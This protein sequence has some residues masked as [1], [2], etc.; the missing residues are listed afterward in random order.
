MKNEFQ[1]ALSNDD[2]HDSSAAKSEL[3]E[4]IDES[5]EGKRADD[6]SFL[7]IFQNEQTNEKN[8]QVH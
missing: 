7:E 1:E 8:N 3:S 4:I 6:Q 5:F 2:E